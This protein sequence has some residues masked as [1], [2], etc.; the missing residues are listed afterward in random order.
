MTVELRASMPLSWHGSCILRRAGIAISSA[1]PL[2]GP[3]QKNCLASTFEWGGPFSCALSSRFVKP[4]LVRQRSPHRRRPRSPRWC[5]QRRSTFLAWSDVVG[6]VAW[7]RRVRTASGATAV[8]ILAWVVKPTSILDTGRVL[9]E[10]GRKAA[11]RR[12][13][14]ADAQHLPDPELDAV[15]A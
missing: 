13:G 6:V 8:Q 2:P 15:L 4:G 1:C 7:I 11:S 5:S 14:P 10:L 3:N 9:A 12:S